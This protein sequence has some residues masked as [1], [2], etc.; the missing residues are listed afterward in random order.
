MLFRHRQSN[1]WMEDHNFL[2]VATISTNTYIPIYGF[3]I[4]NWFW[5][6]YWIPDSC[7]QTF[8]MLLNQSNFLWLCD[9]TVHGSHYCSTND[10]QSENWWL[11]NLRDS[12]NPVALTTLDGLKMIIPKNC[13]QK[14][15]K[16]IWNMQKKN[17]IIEVSKHL[18]GIYKH[19][20]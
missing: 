16:I 3:S 14:Y 15:S 9:A 11:P 19:R 7:A 4:V 13:H 18:A 8:C 12:P 20:P 6:C 1:N 17:Q 10:G 5:N 2:F